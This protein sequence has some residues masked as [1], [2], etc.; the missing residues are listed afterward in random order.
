MNEITIRPFDIASPVAKSKPIRKMRPTT[1]YIMFYK[2][3][4]E[5]QSRKHPKWSAAKITK[6]IKLLWQRAKMQKKA[7]LKAPKEVAMR[8]MSGR[9]MF[10]RFKLK[11][12]MNKE[13]IKNKWKRLPME[14]K[15]MYEVAGNPEAPMMMPRSQAKMTIT[16]TMNAVNRINNDIGQM[17]LRK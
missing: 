2:E 16:T 9:M 6:I 1:T 17:L 13:T 3:N 10:K 5:M 4:F 15:K 8:K 11:E 12:G 14:S 7:K